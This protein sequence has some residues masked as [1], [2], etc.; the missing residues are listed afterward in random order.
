[1][2]VELTPE[3]I[4][5]LFNQT[6]ASK[7]LEKELWEKTLT[8]PARAFYADD[9]IQNWVNEN[10]N[11]VPDP[12]EIAVLTHLWNL[13][14]SFQLTGES[15]SKHKTPDQIRI[16]KLEE[17]V[18]RL[19]GIVEAMQVTQSAQDESLGNIITAVNLINKSL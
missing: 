10:F 16:D 13:T 6:E 7:N 1:M 12:K 4:I 17:Y 18:Q 11:F 3:L 5:K 15:M 14:Y 8:K 2:N 19:L 9:V